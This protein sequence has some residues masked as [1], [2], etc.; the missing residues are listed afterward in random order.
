VSPFRR[1]RD[2]P[3]GYHNQ[4]CTNALP[5]ALLLTLFYALPRYAFDCMRGRA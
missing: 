4:N 1:R 2:D 3:A 5:L